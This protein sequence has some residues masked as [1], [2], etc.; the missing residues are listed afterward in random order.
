MDEMSSAFAS[1]LK[2]LTDA[3]VSKP[4]TA[5]PAPAPPAS[6]PSVSFAPPIADMTLRLEPAG[7]LVGNDPQT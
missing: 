1:G 2:K 6:A 7:Y 3:F 4:A 5:T